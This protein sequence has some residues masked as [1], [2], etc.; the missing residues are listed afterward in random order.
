[1]LVE[2]FPSALT[3]AATG[4]ANT[5]CFVGVMVLPIG[6]GRIADVTDGFEAAF[7]VIATAHGLGLLCGL[8]MRE[9]G[10]A[11]VAPSREA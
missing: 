3:A 8:A 5:A 10:A 6:L 9:T 2:L 1:M 11:R 4:V 7:L